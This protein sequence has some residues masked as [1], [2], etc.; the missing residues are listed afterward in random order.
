MKVS[1]LTITY[2][3]EEFIAQAIDSFL[4][5]QV[6]FDYEIVIG[7]DCSTD[8]T[9]DIVINYQKKY[10]DKIRALLPEKN[11]G[12]QKN[13]LQTLKACQGKYIALCEGDDYWTDPLKL[14]K[15]VDF[16][17]ANS[18]FALCFHN[19]KIES[20]R[21]GQFME[22]I[23]HER[24]EK[25]VFETKD[26]LRQWFIPTASILFRKYNDFV[27]PDFFLH[28]DSGDIPLLLLLS[29]KGNFKYLNQVMS[30][31]RLQDNGVSLTHKDYRKVIS[32]VYI[33]QNFN[34]YTNY[35]YND[36][37]MNAIVHEFNTHLPE[38]RELKELKAKSTFSYKMNQKIKNAIH[39]FRL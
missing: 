4:M 35:R 26:L 29:L 15:Q 25:D 14:Q 18:N 7:E 30:V 5:Q 22:W 27:F 13:F 36:E 21:S 2:N 17:E 34:I 19:A 9:R 20:T 39:R 31:Y 38:I 11:L 32:M 3:H 6:N 16:L 1:V 37:I 23:M 8:N 33:Y 10:P 12:M 24:L 28:C